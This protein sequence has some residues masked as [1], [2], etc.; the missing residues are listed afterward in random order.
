MPSAILPVARDWPLH[1]ASASRALE[2]AAAAALPAHTLMARA[3]RAVARLALA[4]APQAR[5]ICVLAG[6]G[7]NGGDALVAAR[8]LHSCGLAVRVHLL[9]EPARLPAD[10]AWALTSAAGVPLEPGLPAR[11]DSDLLIDGLLG[12]GLA[13]APA[14][15][16]AHAIGWLNNAAAP[17]LAID[18]PSGLDGDHGT[19][20]DGIAVRAQHTLALLS[21]KPGLFTAQ[22]RAHSGQI[23][24]DDLGV[25]P[26]AT[27]TTLAGPPAAD[28]A[29][30]DAHKGRFG[31]LVVIGGAAGMHGAAALA[32]HAA[33]AA[34]AGRVHVGLLDAAGCPALRPEL[35]RR[36]LSAL[37]VPQAL[38]ARTVVA[39]C[40]GGQAIAAVL[41][42][43]LRHAGRLVLD[44]DALNAI[45]ADPALREALGARSR[46]GAATLLTP[47]PLEAARLLGRTAAAVQA[48]RLG[49]ARTLARRLGAV[50]VLK[51]SGTLVARPD[52]TL[53]LHAVGNARLATAGTGDVLAGW[54]G[55]LWSRHAGAPAQAADEAVYRHGHAADSAAGNG[56]LLAADLI[57]A[58]Q[59]VQAAQGPHRA[60]AP[61]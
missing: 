25:A 4:L 21:L 30:H 48:D 32:A 18:L 31:D 28:P 23:W 41:P 33:L 60:S 13:R 6:P 10:A 17:V 26:T 52:G 3:G 44:A 40:G 27:P 37:L 1:D 15:V 14:G 53:T 39:G 46:C 45:A 2:A 34:G 36:D 5:R 20:F 58:M 9:A 43:L 12:L 56:P 22:G 38:Q 55:G 49:A 57:R 47:H 35:M 59:A 50:V 8:W 19:R 51:G 42:A 61:A 11:C 29:S 16:L 7:N 54:M 24:F